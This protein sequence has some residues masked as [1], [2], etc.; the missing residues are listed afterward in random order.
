MTTPGLRKGKCSFC[1][2]DDLNVIRRGD[3]TICT[4]CVY[5]ANVAIG[6]FPK[7]FV[8]CFKCADSVGFVVLYQA[9]SKIGY[10]YAGVDK[11]GQAIYSV[12]ASK[13]VWRR[14]DVPLGATCANC[15]AKIPVWMLEEN[16][17]VRQSYSAPSV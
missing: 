9:G 13:G 15:T 7:G 6:K 11:K 8:H 5:D 16:R 1:A 3:N 17:Y 4:Q 10:H 14:G 2:R 12:L